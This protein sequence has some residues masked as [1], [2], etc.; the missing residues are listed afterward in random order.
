LVLALGQRSASSEEEWSED[1]EKTGR[2]LNEEF[3]KLL[4][5]QRQAGAAVDTK[6]GIVAAAA[7]TGTQFLAAQKTLHVRCQRLLW[8]LWR[9]PS[10]LPTLLSGPE[11]LSRF[12]T[13]GRS[14]SHTRIP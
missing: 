1:E 10:G 3:S 7:V 2:L 11:S 5:V 13:R 9:W 14:T 8:Q 12:L 4:D 6:A